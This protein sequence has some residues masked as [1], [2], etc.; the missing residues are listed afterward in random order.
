MSLSPMFDFQKDLM[1]PGQTQE[2]IYLVPGMESFARCE[3]F[4]QK[5]SLSKKPTLSTASKSMMD[6]FENKPY[7]W[8]C[9]VIKNRD[10]EKE[11]N[12]W[13]PFGSQSHF[14]KSVFICKKLGL[15]YPQ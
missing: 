5:P 12:E 3:W 11:Y 9:K 15:L 1:F 2:S 8:L 13:A 14:H 4:G 6:T 7:E 10:W